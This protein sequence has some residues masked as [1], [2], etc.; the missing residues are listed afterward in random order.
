MWFV[1]TS[2]TRPQNDELETIGLIRGCPPSWWT[3][4]EKPIFIHHPVVGHHQKLGNLFGDLSTWA[5]Y[6]NSL[7]WILRPFTFDKR[8][9]PC[10]SPR[11]DPRTVRFPSYIRKQMFFVKLLFLAL[12]T[13][14]SSKK[15][16]VAFWLP[17]VF[18]LSFFSVFHSQSLLCN[19]TSHLKKVSRLIFGKPARD[20]L[21]LCM[22]LAKM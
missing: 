9:P 22:K 3:R 5:N 20:L 13:Q 14:S 2:G 18:F 8:A 6:N 1:R 21:L 17:A 16:C 7:T 15:C 19:S 12:D 10:L 11:G 4:D